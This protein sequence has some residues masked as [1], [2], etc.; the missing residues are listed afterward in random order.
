MDAGENTIIAGLDKRRAT[1][2]IVFQLHGETFKR[3]LK[4]G[5]RREAHGIA[6]AV[7]RTINLIERGDLSLPNGVDVATFLIADSW[8]ERPLKVAPTVDTSL[9]AVVEAYLSSITEGSLEQSTIG[10]LTTHLHYFR[11][12]LGERFDLA[13]LGFFGPPEIHRPTGQGSRASW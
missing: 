1:F 8:V 12:V 6:A 10:T 11:R 2:R 13:A 9:A 7:Q 4:S 5:A 3:F